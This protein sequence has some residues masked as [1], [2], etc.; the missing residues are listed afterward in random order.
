MTTEDLQQL[1][2]RSA[3]LLEEADA[4]W[5]TGE[6][7]ELAEA[8]QMYREAGEMRERIAELHL[9][10]EQ[11]VEA[12]MSLLGA[13]SCYM[14]ATE[15][16]RA[17]RALERALEIPYLHEALRHE[18][19]RISGE[20]GVRVGQADTSILPLEEQARPARQNASIIV[21]TMAEAARSY[22]AP[23]PL[24]RATVPYKNLPRGVTF[25]GRCGNVS[26]MASKQKQGL[27][28]SCV[29]DTRTPGLT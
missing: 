13:G 23:L 10:S 25:C 20:W 29:I 14:R 5:A 19:V 28:F 6:S 1:I 11:G 2:G 15:F 16:D 7:V 12:V 21:N 27:C 26:E 18:I 4:R 8:A 17:G 9:Q 24:S 22:C 3:S